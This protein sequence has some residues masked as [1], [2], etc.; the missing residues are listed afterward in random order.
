MAVMRGITSSDIR[1]RAL[2]MRGLEGGTDIAMAF[3]H[4][5]LESPDHLESLA[6]LESIALV[7]TRGKEVR[8]ICTN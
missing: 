7:C 5:L 3:E 2:D 1:L 8:I 6:S 4:F